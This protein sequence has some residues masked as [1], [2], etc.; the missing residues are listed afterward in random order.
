MNRDQRGPW[1]LLTGLVLGVALGLVYAWVLAPVKYVDTVP[2][3][4]REDYK[5]QY[6]ALV[7]AAYM[8]TGD[9]PL[10]LIHI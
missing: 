8:A 6:R 9:L 1:Y 4:L 3:M 10:S 2:D 7:A 5:A